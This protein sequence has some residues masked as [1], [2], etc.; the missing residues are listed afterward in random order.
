MTRR[1]FLVAAASVMLLVCALSTRGGIFWLLFWLLCLL[2]LQ[3]I[4]A[5]LWTRATLEVTCTLDK[6]KITREDSVTFY[7]D[8]LHRC[9]LP[10]APLRL[11][12]Y[13]EEN[14]DKYT[15]DATVTPMQVNKMSYSRRC[16]HVG[17]FYSG[18]EAVYFSD[19][20]G[21]FSARRR[22]SVTNRELAVLPQVYLT[23]P[24]TFS[25]GDSDDDS[26]TARAFEDATMPTDIRAF[27][28]GDELKKIHWKLSMRRKELLVR[29]Y[30][31]PQ[32]PDALL[33]V[34]CAPPDVPEGAAAVVRDAICEATA[35][36]AAAAL[37][38]G[39]PVRMPLVG[40]HP[41]E[42]STSKLDEIDLF[43]DALAHCA[44][45]AQEQFERVLLLETRRMRRTGTTAI[46]TSRLN[47][48]MADMILRI[49]RMGPRVRVMTTADMDDELVSMLAQRL[50]RNDI[51]VDGIE[52][53]YREPVE[54]A[55][56]GGREFV[57]RVAR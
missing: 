22:L 9:L 37:E 11:E 6:E 4:I 55:E 5:V 25:P 48:A 52:L 12:L 18:I 35:S 38:G 8:I 46:I 43:R 2:M 36:L 31:Q 7:I 23:P 17:T 34:D 42:I 57:A 49:R 45:D 51:E 28:Q 44:F 10:V 13:T 41:V 29:V 47:P 3:G 33:L 56:A 54:E 27:Q 14:G 16:D 50:M 40:E 15:I 21:L 26:V 30:E 24:L 53:V 19:I 32:K 20:F 39:A 1:A